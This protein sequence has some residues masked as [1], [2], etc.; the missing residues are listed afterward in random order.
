VA[1]LSYLPSQQEAEVEIDPTSLEDPL[2]KPSGKGVRFVPRS[3]T[4]LH[5]DFPVVMTGEITGTVYLK[6]TGKT[7]EFPGL[8]V[9][10]V[11]AKDKVVKRC[12]R[13]G[14]TGCGR[15]GYDGYY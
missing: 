13:P 7:R 6:E 14:A 4:V 11:D 10:I 3:G 1:F 12:D 5:L 2:M 15:T 9:E 8:Y